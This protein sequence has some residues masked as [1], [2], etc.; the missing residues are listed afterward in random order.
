MPEEEE[1]K[2]NIYDTQRNRCMSRE[3]EYT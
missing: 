2:K 3:Y 1:Q